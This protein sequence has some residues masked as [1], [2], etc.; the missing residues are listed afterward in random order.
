[1]TA[2]HRILILS[3]L[4][5]T[6]TA[7]ASVPA[8]AAFSRQRALPVTTIATTTVQPPAGVSSEGSWCN[9]GV[10]YANFSWA[11]SPTAGVSGYSVRTYQTDGSSKVFAETDAAG[12]AVT[13]I[14]PS[15]GQAATTA[16]TVTTRTSYGWT[17][18][19]AKSPVPAC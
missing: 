10:L 19:S 16:I 4:T 11:P 12:T 18:D 9:N 1:M 17:A 6:V 2:I 13:G 15:H 7:G 8:W 3:V 5:V 14:Y